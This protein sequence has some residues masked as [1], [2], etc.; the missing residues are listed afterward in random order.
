MR[1]ASYLGDAQQ[2]V[3][4]RTAQVAATNTGLLHSESRRN[5]EAS[6]AITDNRGVT[7]KR[8]PRY[9]HDALG[10]MTRV[11]S[12]SEAHRRFGFTAPCS[13]LL[14]SA[15]LPAPYLVQSAAKA[16]LTVAETYSKGKQ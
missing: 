13:V 9:S 6:V 8:V 15:L 5:G 10:V 2:G 7:V 12:G 11:G 14:P 16:V 3:Y 4:A 1:V